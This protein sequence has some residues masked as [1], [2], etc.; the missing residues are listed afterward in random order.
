MRAADALWTSVASVDPPT[1]CAALV[2]DTSVFSQQ[3]T[4]LSKCAGP[5]CVALR[6]MYEAGVSVNIKVSA[7]ERAAEL[8]RS[9]IKYNRARRG[10]QFTIVCHEEQHRR[11][12]FQ[13]RTDGG[14]PRAPS[15]SN[16]SDVLDTFEFCQAA[17]TQSGGAVRG[18][19]R[20]SLLAQT[21]DVEGPSGHGQLAGPVGPAAVAM[22]LL[23][24]VEN[25]LVRGGF[26]F[27]CPPPAIAIDAVRMIRAKESLRP[28]TR[29]RRPAGRHVRPLHRQHYALLLCRP[30]DAEGS[31][32]ALPGPLRVL[33]FHRCGQTQGLH[34]GA[35]TLSNG[36]TPI[37]P[38]GPRRN[39]AATLA[40]TNLERSQIC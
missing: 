35:A 1:H 26:S 12:V 13:P 10:P 38:P 37:L 40:R 25:D 11:N 16:P 23:Q 32:V 5:H 27:A 9:M 19:L 21:G 20:R 34:D 17:L 3:L 6:R 24:G 28:H 36:R 14:K 7:K 18:H 4:G 8:W 31:P 39:A 22:F 2:F 15:N 30:G 33:P 29:P